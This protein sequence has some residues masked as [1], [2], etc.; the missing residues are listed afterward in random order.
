MFEAEEAN[1]CMAIDGE[2]GSECEALDPAVVG[3]L[4]GVER[5]AVDHLTLVHLRVER[6]TGHHWLCDR[7][8]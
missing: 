8:R 7:W 1:K 3:V 2:R 4:V 6:L 5:C